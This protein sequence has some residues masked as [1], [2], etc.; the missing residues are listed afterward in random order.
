MAGSPAKMCRAD[1]A[2]PVHRATRA[3][4]NGRTTAVAQPLGDALGVS[5]RAPDRCHAARTG[6][7]PTRRNE[8]AAQLDRHPG[9]PS[10]TSI[11]RSAGRGSERSSSTTC[12]GRPHHVADDRPPRLEQRVRRLGRRDASFASGYT[13]P[14]TA[15]VLAAV[16]TVNRKTFGNELSPTLTALVGMFAVTAVA[17]SASAS[18]SI[19]TRSLCRPRGALGAHGRGLGVLGPREQLQHRPVADRPGNR[20]DWHVFLVIAWLKQPRQ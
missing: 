14:A 15:G 18:S 7:T 5:G 2:A 12:S 4:G 8:R 10:R 1:D 9:A 17:R 16:L 6:E 19:W 20:G 3:R 13:H 11:G